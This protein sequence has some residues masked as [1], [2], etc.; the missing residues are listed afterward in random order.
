MYFCPISIGSAQVPGEVGRVVLVTLLI[1][2][3]LKVIGCSSLRG[4][5]GELG[6]IK[7]LTYGSNKFA[8]NLN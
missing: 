7:T 8:Q 5:G 3:Q 4:G 2:Q 6:T 1:L